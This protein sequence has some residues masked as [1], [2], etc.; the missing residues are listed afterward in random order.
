MIGASFSFLAEAYLL[1]LW[2][3]LTGA[4]AFILSLSM[5]F[6]SFSMISLLK[7]SATGELMS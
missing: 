4:A 1:S 2:G 6:N 5:M 7:L 3:G